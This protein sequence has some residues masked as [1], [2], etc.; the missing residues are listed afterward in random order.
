MEAVA[1]HAIRN[2]EVNEPSFMGPIEDLSGSMQDGGK[3]SPRRLT[4]EILYLRVLSRMC[5]SG[6]LWS[7]Q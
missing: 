4:M 2:G 1:T 7:A 5:G 3:P 6:K